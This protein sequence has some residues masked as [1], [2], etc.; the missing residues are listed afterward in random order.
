[1]SMNDERMIER[2]FANVN[3]EHPVMVW[4]MERARTTNPR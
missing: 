2:W 4:L 3:R 1:M